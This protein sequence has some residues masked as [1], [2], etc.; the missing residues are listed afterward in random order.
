MTTKYPS[1]EN[2]VAALSKLQQDAVLKGWQK[3]ERSGGFKARPDAFSAMPAAPKGG[4][5]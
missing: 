5:R 1:F 2:A 4:A 3:A